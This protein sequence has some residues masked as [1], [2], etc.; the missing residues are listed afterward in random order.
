MGA[1]VHDGDAC[2]TI[3]NQ[4]AKLERIATAGDQVFAVAS[5]VE[6]LVALAETAFELVAMVEV[7]ASLVDERKAVFDEAPPPRFSP[8]ATLRASQRH[9][10]NIQT[11]WHA[12]AA[13]WARRTVQ[14]DALPPIAIRQTLIEL[15][16]SQR[17][18]RK[19]QRHSGGPIREVGTWPEPIV[20]DEL[21]GCAGDDTRN[22]HV[23]I[24]VVPSRKKNL[25][26]LTATR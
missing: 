17:P 11:Q 25:T 14:Y 5:N 20:H 9:A 23:P 4:I 26:E 24:S 12:R 22:G 16:G 7:E 13:I 21:R 2:Q 15:C 8:H 10:V 1:P 3:I 18:C 6:R 19:P